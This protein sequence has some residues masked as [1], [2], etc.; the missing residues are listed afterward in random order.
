MGASQDMT[1]RSEL[2]LRG[3]LTATATALTLRLSVFGY[4]SSA[5]NLATLDLP[6]IKRGCQ[7]VK[8]TGAIASCKGRKTREGAQQNLVFTTVTCKKFSQVFPAQQRP[9]SR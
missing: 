2:Y 6:H 1:H 9:V 5:K 8:S 7:P 4:Y 3:L